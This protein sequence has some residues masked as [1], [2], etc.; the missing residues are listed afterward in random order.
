MSRRA[1]KVGTAD[2]ATGHPDHVDEVGHRLGNPD[3]FLGQVGARVLGVGPDVPGVVN[4]HVVEEH[5]DEL[6]SPRPAP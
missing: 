5:L 3:I 6:L 1:M 2:E 4:E